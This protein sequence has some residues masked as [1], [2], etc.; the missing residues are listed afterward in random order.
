MKMIEEACERALIRLKYQSIMP[1]AA[2]GLLM[3]MAGTNSRTILV[4]L[5]CIFTL[6]I[7]ATW[8]VRAV[9]TGDMEFRFF[10]QKLNVPHRLSESFGLSLF[11]YL[12]LLILHDCQQVRDLRH[13][14]SLN[15]I[16]HLVIWI[17]HALTMSVLLASCMSEILLR[18]LGHETDPEY[19]PPEMWVSLAAILM[20]CLFSRFSY[21]FLSN[22]IVPVW[23][24]MAAIF[25]VSAKCLP[26]LPASIFG[27][28]Y[29]LCFSM[30]GLGLIVLSFT[31]IVALENARDKLFPVGDEMFDWDDLD[32]EAVGESRLYSLE[33]C[34]EVMT[35]RWED[36]ESSTALL[37]DGGVEV[38]VAETGMEEE[39]Q[40]VVEAI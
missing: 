12:V 15:P 4:A 32:C 2:S 28:A 5:R 16:T 34:K 36:S 11:C 24:V 14:K 38:V 39:E 37:Q 10:P 6:A 31:I 29:K 27:R 35:L 23:T 13:M 20:E 9:L 7:P 25:F 30:I 40:I 17:L 21:H 26:L 22:A 8:T 3:R 1:V 33:D 18:I 19:I